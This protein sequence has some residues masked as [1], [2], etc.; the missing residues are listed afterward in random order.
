[1]LLVGTIILVGF[2]ADAFSRRSFIPD[3]LILILLGMILGHYTG[4]LPPDVFL[5]FAGFMASIAVAIILFDTGLNI[6]LVSTIKESGQ[7]FVLGTISYAA[8]TILISLV[9][10]TILG[11]DPVR[12]LIL[13]A[14]LGGTSAAVVASISEKL[15]I[16]EKTKVIL[17]VESTLTNAYALLFVLTLLD[18]VNQP[19]DP[20]LALSNVVSA[21]SVSL[22]LGFIGGILWMGV[23]LKSQRRPYFPVLSMGIMFLLYA[24]VEYMGG[25]GAIAAFIF[26]LVLGNAETVKKMLFIREETA[27]NREFIRFSDEISFFIRVFFFVYLGVIFV[28]PEEAN[29]YLSSV[30]IVVAALLSRFIGIRLTS[31]PDEEVVLISIPR[32]LSEAVVASLLYSMEFPSAMIYLQVA[33]LVIILTNVATAVLIPFVMRKKHLS[34]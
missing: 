13:G 10:Y 6:D 15:P 19:L 27:L 20:M 11:L 28:P 25:I 21:L 3:S 32:G 16:S 5:S 33:S 9:G 8:A 29:I 34:S 23:L 4:I 31:P 14:M 7:A 17:D 2:L 22:V 30:L 12:S 24:L 1:M 18:F 26:G